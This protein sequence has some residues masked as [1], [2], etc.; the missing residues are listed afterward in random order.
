ML[1]EHEANRLLDV[2]SHCARC[3]DESD[4]CGVVERLKGLGGID[5]RKDTSPRLL[6]IA[7]TI[8]DHL[9]V[10]LRA[11]TIRALEGRKRNQRSQDLLSPREREILAWTKDGKS[12]WEI[13][14]ILAISDE[15]VKFHLRNV[16]RKLGVTN[17]TQAVAVALSAGLIDP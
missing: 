13:S 16:M 12:R 8:S 1:P 3:R 9:Q 17:R 7:K 6:A 11:A 4:L 2:I 5:L 14:R 15:T 10:H